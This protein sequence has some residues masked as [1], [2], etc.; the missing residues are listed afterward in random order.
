MCVAQL[1]ASLPDVV[2]FEKYFCSTF[3]MIA[4][5]WL[6][7]SYGI[8]AIAFV[9]VFTFG[10]PV[11]CHPLTETKGPFWKFYLCDER[12]ASPFY[13]QKT[14][15]TLSYYISVGGGAGI[16]GMV[17]LTPIMLEF[18]WNLELRVAVRILRARLEELRQLTDSD[19]EEPENPSN[20]NP[21]CNSRNALLARLVENLQQKARLIDIQFYIVLF[22][23][24]SFQGILC[25]PITSSIAMHTTISTIAAVF[26][27]V[28]F[29]LALLFDFRAL[30][31]VLYC[32]GVV[33]E[34]IVGILLFIV[35]IT[36]APGEVAAWLPPYQYSYWFLESM[37]FACYLCLPM[38][39]FFVVT[40]DM[41]V[42]FLLDIPMLK[43][44]IES[45]NEVPYF[46]LE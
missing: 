39:H 22:F 45:D 14:A 11:L 29:L 31:A 42:A 9:L 34:V 35:G 30:P 36:G 38:A 40:A 25:V 2:A 15:P 21:S 27:G 43:E 44:C 18:I 8:A 3:P 41:R 10:M 1:G 16:Y 46:K 26:A 13:L 12:W 4:R 23:A 5:S 19:S 28:H 33:C 6:N 37:S 20:F 32:L 7:Y 17:A 24:F